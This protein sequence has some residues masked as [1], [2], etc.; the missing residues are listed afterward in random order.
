[1]KKSLM[2]LGIAAMAFASCTQN[3]VLEVNQ[4]RAIGFDGFVGNSTRATDVT[5]ATLGS[6]EL[7][8]WRDTDLIFNKQEVSVGADGT[9]TYTPVQYWEANYTYAFEAIAPGN[10]VNGVTIAPAKTGGAITFDSD[11]ETDLIYAKAG[12]VTTPEKIESAPANVG[13]EFKHLLSRVKFTFENAFPKGAAAKITVKDVTITN[14]NTQGSITPGAK[15]D[16]TWTV[17]GEPK[18]VS[19]PSTS[20]VNVGAQ[21]SQATDHKYLIPVTSHNFN[22]TFTVEFSQADG[23]SSTYTHDVDFTA[24]LERGNSYNFTAELKPGN[25]NPDSQLFPIEFKASEV[26]W[27]DFPNPGTDIDIPEVQQ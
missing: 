27:T 5:L 10:G 25:I 24:T 3:E 1:M 9:C 18:E 22:L 8:G 21:S 17:N 15:N 20:I 6:F 16:Q 2:F 11:G 4:S 23:V 14:A 26:D 19:F 7:Y 13:L 12:D